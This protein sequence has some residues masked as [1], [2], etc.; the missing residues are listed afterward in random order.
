MGKVT[1]RVPENARREVHSCPLCQQA[2]K[3]EAKLSKRKG[4]DGDFVER[5]ELF[6][7]SCGLRAPVEAWEAICGIMDNAL[8]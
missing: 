1:L 8:D 3:V 4:A 5:V 6:C 7:E 2:P